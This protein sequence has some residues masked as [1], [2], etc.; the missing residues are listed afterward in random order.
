MK[1]TIIVNRDHMIDGCP[2]DST[3][4]AIALAVEDS[5]LV[6]ENESIDVDGAGNISVERIADASDQCCASYETIQ[7]RYI[8]DEMHDD[9]QA[10]IAWYDRATDAEI[11]SDGNKMQ[12][13]FELEREDM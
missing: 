5:G 7:F 4:C 10:F 11:M 2:E 1:K 9:A 8:T 6:R 13:S 12:F 3:F